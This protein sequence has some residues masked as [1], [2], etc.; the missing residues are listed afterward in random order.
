MTGLSKVLS[1]RRS[2][3]LLPLSSLWQP[4]RGAMGESALRFI[5]WLA[6]AGFSVWQVLPL[7]PVGTAGSPYWSRSDR[8]GDSLM[9]D[10][11]LGPGSEAD[12]EAFR[13]A[14]R[15]AG[16]YARFKRSAI[17]RGGRRGGNGP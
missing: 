9:I 17:I 3:V 2:G 8:A 5:D 11:P 1:R 15:L 10:Q 7:V 13:N 6:D 16:R 12:F 14:L 4:G